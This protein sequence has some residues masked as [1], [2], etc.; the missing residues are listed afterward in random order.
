M[1]NVL[2]VHGKW[3]GKRCAHIAYY[4]TCDQFRI[5]EARGA[6]CCEICHRRLDR[7]QI[8]H[9]PRRGPWAVRGLLCVSCNS[10]LESGG[11]GLPEQERYLA[12]AWY[13]SVLIPTP[14]EPGEG[15]RVNGP[16][17]RAWVRTRKGWERTTYR[18]L[19]RMWTWPGLCREYGPHNLAILEAGI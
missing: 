9:D 17:Q 16:H 14:T 4:L 15:A 7:P 10:R 19:S 8:D 6:G 2:S 13:L 11:Q 5:I 3:P 1:E 12:A 18:N